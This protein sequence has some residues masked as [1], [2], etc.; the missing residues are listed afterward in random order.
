MSIQGL[1]VAAHLPGK[2]FHAGTSRR[3]DEVVVS[4]G[5]VFC[6]VG[7]GET[8]RAAQADAYALVSS[9]GYTG[10]QFRRDIGFRAIA[11]E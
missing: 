11:R 2:L 4:G 10:M 6:A 3:G 9:I 8:V 5:R 1:E 7:L